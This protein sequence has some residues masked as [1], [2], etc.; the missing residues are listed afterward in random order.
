MGSLKTSLLNKDLPH[1][2]PLPSISVSYDSSLS[3]LPVAR[4]QFSLMAEYF[5]GISPWLITCAALYTVQGVPQ[6]EVV[7]IEKKPSVS[8]SWDAYGSAR[9]KKQTYISCLLS[10]QLRFDVFVP[11]LPGPLSSA[12]PRWCPVCRDLSEIPSADL[13]W[14]AV[15]TTKALPW[16]YCG[17]IAGCL[18]SA[19]SSILADIKSSCRG[20]GDRN[21]AKRSHAKW[22]R[23]LN[24][25]LNDL[26]SVWIDGHWWYLLLFMSLWGLCF[27][28]SWAAEFANYGGGGTEALTTLSCSIIFLML[29]KTGWEVSTC[30]KMTHVKSFLHQ[31]TQSKVMLKHS[32]A[33]YIPITGL[34]VLGFVWQSYAGFKRP[35]L[36]SGLLTLA[37]GSA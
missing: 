2:L 17:I 11:S 8:W 19:G 23:G 9:S 28:W 36:W 34:G 14:L 6:S 4:V 24:W 3:V 12:V 37:F 35:C 31:T 5:S 15:P 33:P 18:I 21:C 25:R 22:N 30:I 7:P 29:L 16:L 27:W 32:N 20:L 1:F 10:L 26:S 13:R